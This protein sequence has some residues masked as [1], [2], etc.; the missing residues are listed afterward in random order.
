MRTLGKTLKTAQ[1]VIM[2]VRFA[3]C[4]MDCIWRVRYGSKHSKRC[5]FNQ[6]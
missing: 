1:A 3:F 2:Y 5:F 4:R 6:V